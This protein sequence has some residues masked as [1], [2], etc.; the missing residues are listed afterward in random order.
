VAG[1]ADRLADRSDAAFA[2]ATGGRAVAAVGIGRPAFGWAPAPAGPT[3]TPTFGWAAAPT[4][5]ANA[6]AY[7]GATDPTRSSARFPTPTFSIPRDP[8]GC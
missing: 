6:P 2:V 8:R 3:S 7:S 4:A 1:A 5:P